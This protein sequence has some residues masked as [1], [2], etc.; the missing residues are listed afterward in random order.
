MVFEGSIAVTGTPGVGKS[1]FANELVKHTELPLR[2]LEDIATEYNCLA[3]IDEIDHTLLVDT[4]CIAGIH[5]F[6]ST[7]LVIDG[8]LS[9]YI[10]T[11]VIIILRCHPTTLWQRLFDRGYSQE[12]IDSNV[13]WEFISGTRS[14]IEQG[15]GA[16]ILE[17]DSTSR[18]V[19][20]LCKEV[21]HWLMNLETGQEATHSQKEPIDWFEH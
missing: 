9:H 6:L 3:G 18:G 1:T 17:I 15:S 11:D 5:N 14:E 20:S 8:H 2:S 7:P 12:K 16:A 10:P 19:D 21:I 4:E 13:E